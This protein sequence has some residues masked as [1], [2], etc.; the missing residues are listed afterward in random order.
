MNTNNLDLDELAHRV[1]HEIE[2]H[3]YEIP[4]HARRPLPDEKV[5]RLLAEMRAALVEPQWGMVE[6]RDTPEQMS[7]DPPEVRRCVLIADDGEVYQLYFDPSDNEFV[8]TAGDPPAT[9][10]VR[11]DAVGC[12][13]AR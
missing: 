12:F 13:M 11:G 3:R 1:L 8:L 2:S 10:G 7:L 9:F 6:Q 4:D 5:Q